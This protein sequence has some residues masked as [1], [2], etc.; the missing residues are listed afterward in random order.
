MQIYICDILGQC[1]I[2]FISLKQHPGTPDWASRRPSLTNSIN[3]CN[4]T[5]SSEVAVLAD[6][7]AIK[8][9]GQNEEEDSGGGGRAMTGNE[10]R[11]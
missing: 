7:E 2:H 9:V 1:L 11:G 10:V 8:E 5:L 6:D 4:Y 3:S